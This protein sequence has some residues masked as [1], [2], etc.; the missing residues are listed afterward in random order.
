MS[1]G[2]PAI[3][4]DRVAYADKIVEALEA[5]VESL[6]E[7][8][9]QP[10]QVQSCFID[11]VLPNEWASMVFNAFPNPAEMMER[12]SLR[13]HKFVAAQ[14]DRYSPILE[15]IIYAFQDP[16]IV[17]LAEQINYWNSGYDS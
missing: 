15:E 5:N 1:T 7:S 3:A 2:K 8:F 10:N 13:E 12:K 6:K 11:D 14:M 16:H 9:Q 17:K 4:I